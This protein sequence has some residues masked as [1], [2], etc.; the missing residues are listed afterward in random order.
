MAL[1][2]ELVSHNSINPRIAGHAGGEAALA[3]RIESLARRWPGVRVRREPFDGGWNLALTAP[4]T[5]SDARWLFFEAHLDTVGVDGMTIDPFVPR[6]RGGRLHGRGACD[7][8]ASVAAMLWALRRHAARAVRPRHIGVVLTV[9]EEVRMT[10]SIAWARGGLRRL[11]ARC[12]G[13]VVGE[14]TR[15]RPVAAHTG[16][17]RW[18]ME[19]RGRAA[20]SSAPWKGRSAISMMLPVVDAFERRYVPGLRARHPLTGRATGSINVI[21]GGDLVNIVPARC[22]VECDRRVVPGEDVRSVWAEIRAFVAG[23]RRRDPELRLAVRGPPYLVP[24]LAPARGAGIYDDVSAALMANGLPGR[25]TGA[26]FGTNASQYAAAGVAALVLGPG[27]IAQAHTA[28]EWVD[29]D[30]VRRASDVYL[31]LMGRCAV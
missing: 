22:A 28:D 11:R 3:V 14:P 19:T 18:A 10:G 31:S 20:H 21:R 30:E 5:E 8:K 7:T 27:D 26:R 23:L 4:A 9:D 1:L 29:L 6:V 13:V 12:D 17:V 2:R 24:A 25:M 15:L 16:I